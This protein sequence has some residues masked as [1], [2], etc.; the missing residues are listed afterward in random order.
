MN[1]DIFSGDP[2]HRAL[3]DQ[4]I[5]TAKEL[6]EARSALENSE[7]YRAMVEEENA[8]LRDAL[9]MLGEVQT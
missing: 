8:R 5:K 2:L 7:N 4:L 3:T 6:G 1:M 9:A